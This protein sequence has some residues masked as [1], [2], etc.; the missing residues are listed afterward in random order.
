MAAC[1]RWGLRAALFLAVAGVLGYLSLFLI[2][3]SA[4]FQRWL[5]A[6]ITNRSGYEFNAG[7]LTVLPPLRLTASAATISQSSKPLLQSEKIA[8]TLSPIGLFS[9]SI[10][11]LELVKPTVHLNLQ[12]LFASSSKTSLNIAIRHLK[13]QDGTVVLVTGEGESVDFRSINVDAENL[14][15]GETAGLHLSTDLPWLNGRANISIRGQNDE[16]IVALRIQQP[17][18]QKPGLLSAPK[19]SGTLVADIKL[20]KK[21]TGELEIHTAGQLNQFDIG[22]SNWIGPFTVNADV[23][24]AFKQVIFSAKMVAPALPVN[25]ASVPLVPNKGP[26]TASLTGNFSI[27]EKQTQLKSVRLETSFW[28][29]DGNGNLSFT[30]QPIALNVRFFIRNISL[31][32]LKPLLPEW[33]GAWTYRGVTEADVQVEGHWRAL[34]AHGVARSEGTQFTSPNFSLAQLSLKAPFQW[35]NGS[36]QV[37]DLQLAGKT[38][39]IDRKDQT[40]ISAEEVLVGADFT[41]TNTDPLKSGGKFEIRRGRF[42]NSDGSKAGENLTLNARFNATSTSDNNFHSVVGKVSFEQGEVLWG[43][44]Y[45]DLKTVRPGLDFDGDYT[46]SNEAIR[47]RRLN[48]SLADIGTID[49]SGKF[50]RATK[51][52]ALNILVQS[53]GINLARFFEFFIRDPLKTSHP[54]LDQLVPA[55]QVSFAAIAQGPSDDLSITGNLHL[56]AGDLRAKSDKWQVG[57]INL[58]LPFRIHLPAAKPATATTN[59]GTGTLAIAS[60]R[61]GT[62]VISPVKTRISLRNNMLKFEQPIRISIYEGM[63]GL[64][65]LVWKDFIANPQEFSLSVDAQSLQLQRLTESLGW[66]RLAGMISGSIPKVESAGNMLRSYGE[67]QTQVFGGRIQLS[68]MEIENPFSSVR[69]IKL[70]CRFQDVDLEQASKTFEFGRIS[71]ILESSVTGLVITNGQPAQLLAE[72]HTVEKSGVSQWIS[73]EALN[74]L[75]VLSSGNN[76]GALYGGLAGLFD[77]F[78]YSKLGFNATLKN[79]KLTLRGI[80]SRDGQEYLVVGSRIPPTVNVISH[81]QEISF[82]ELVRRLDQIQKS[83]K[84]QI[85]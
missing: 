29:A 79:D 28:T 67:I 41:K 56:R 37:K 45:G 30:Q 55:G 5:Q 13:I 34:A 66:Y 36:L 19:E 49:L 72:V 53:G 81:T 58:A 46:A 50:D 68:K 9:G 40:K 77:N 62:E 74:K 73:V 69:S 44:F 4:H 61:F 70:D 60:A 71:G 17:S 10:Y 7:D 2:V 38:L 59:I 1:K 51:T 48:L 22:D 6:E 8:V 21:E 31:E 24:A 82:G 80:E 18:V 3:K 25:I 54:L 12:E 64:N 11:G 39:A 32:A 16:K 65:N 35:T 15:L 63:I 26:V 23:D 52:P 85:K 83:D 84:P 20:H 76:A 27:P 57:P 78:R 75:T 47:L 43:K 33:L 42:T 14:N